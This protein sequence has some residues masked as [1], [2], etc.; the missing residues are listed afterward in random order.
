M[1]TTDPVGTGPA[2][3]GG[4]SVT[5]S[6][7]AGAADDAG[8]G[9]TLGAVAAAGVDSGFCSG[10]VGAGS[11]AF[12]CAVRR[13]ALG[14]CVP[15]CRLAG[16][17]V[18]AFSTSLRPRIQLVRGLLSPSGPA[19]LVPRR[20]APSE[21][22]RPRRSSPT[23]RESARSGAADGG[24]RLRIGCRRRAQTASLRRLPG[25]PS[26]E[27]T[28]SGLVV[29]R[30]GPAPTCVVGP[31]G[32][33]ERESRHEGSGERKQGEARPPTVNPPIPPLPPPQRAPSM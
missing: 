29:S 8:V 23:P 17:C 7:D 2:V 14:G 25:H 24:A 31:G 22:P 21:G 33:D 4:A 5:T 28:R 1:A 10:Q 6:S 11:A 12:G 19:R 3:V 26:P 13:G 27:W 9:A 32:V 20:P 15:A 18:G 16:A 30:A